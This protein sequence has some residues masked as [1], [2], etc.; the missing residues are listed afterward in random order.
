ME[1]QTSRSSPLPAS[2][3]QAGG[4][5]M[6]VVEMH[7]MIHPMGDVEF[8]PLH[9][10]QKSR[11]Q[12]PRVARTR[13]HPAHQTA[14]VVRDCTGDIRRTGQVQRQVQ[15]VHLGSLSWVVAQQ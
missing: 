8:L 2:G 3:Q 11:L 4:T 14:I 5:G 10:A 15:L 6:Y 12:G 1:P 9:N 7:S 13:G